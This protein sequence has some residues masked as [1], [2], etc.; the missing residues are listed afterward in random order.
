MGQI[1]FKAK[2]KSDELQMQFKNIFLLSK[3]Y[4]TV[5]SKLLLQL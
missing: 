1:I 3:K 4:F 2:T 5:L